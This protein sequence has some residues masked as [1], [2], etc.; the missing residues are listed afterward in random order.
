MFVGAESAPMAIGELSAIVAVT[1]DGGSSGRLRVERQVP[2]PGDIRNC[3]VAL[4]EDSLLLS[5]LFRHRFEG[6]AGLGGHNFG[7]LFLTAL[8]EITGDFAEAVRLSSE[9]LAIKGRIYP[10]TTDDVHLVAELDDG[11]CVFGETSVSKAGR[12]IR[13]VRLDPPGCRPLAEAIEAIGAADIITVGPGSLFTSLVPPLL[14]DGV[15]EAVASSPAVK[16]LVNNLMTQPGETDG[17]SSARH[18]EVLREYA[19][20]IKFDWLLVNDRPISERQRLLYEFEGAEQ[21]GVHGSVER[22]A[23]IEGTRVIYDNLLDDGDKVRHHPE[24]LARAILACAAAS[25]SAVDD[26]AG[27]IR[28]TEFQ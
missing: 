21:I 26:A 9:V 10:A 5:R 12:K 23:R 1:D 28:Q 7:N 24:R 8:T 27:S 4:G 19:P 11:S 18:L 25:R 2:P 16:V 14:V 3:M 22:I 20:E 13:R 15:A 17:F 6:E